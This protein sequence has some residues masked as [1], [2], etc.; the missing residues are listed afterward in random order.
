MR[1]GIDASQLV[2]WQKTGIEW[3][4]Y[5]VVKEMRHVVPPEHRVRLYA[6]CALPQKFLPLPSYWELKILRWPLPWGW[7]QLRLAWELI[8]NA[9]DIYFTPGYIIP[10]LLKEKAAVSIHDVAFRNYP[11][12]YRHPR[13]NELIHR[14]NAKRAQ[15][16][17]VPSDATK[18]AVVNAYHIDS[19]KIHVIP[20][21]YDHTIYHQYGKAEIQ[22]TFNRYR[23][24]DPYVI[25]V[26][27]V[28]EK[29]N[30]ISV[31]A[32]V[33]EA[34]KRSELKNLILV[35]VGSPGFGYEE[36]QRWIKDHHAQDWVRELGWLPSEDVAVLMN[37]A[38]SLLALSCEEGFGLTVL[39]ALA[40]GT[41]VLASDIPA[42]REVGAEFVTYVDR[43]NISAISQ[44]ITKINNTPE[45]KRQKMEY[46]SQFTWRHAA[47]S[48]YEKLVLIYEI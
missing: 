42:H 45:K 36:I 10:L 31:L 23:L 25:T 46:A 29:K 47:Q 17:I 27:R 16:I 44:A 33:E 18:K 7:T 35:L 3:Y 15:I 9:P 24:T 13:L 11:S 28:E 30:I 20:H 1:I 14:W 34:R 5:H 43:M 12:A 19:E 39:E 8:R 37:G 26:G 38:L 22:K 48:I 4:S 32:A 41:T 6:P 2:K 21:G 40:C